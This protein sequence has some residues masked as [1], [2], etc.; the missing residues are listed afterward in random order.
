[1]IDFKGKTILVTGGAG[2]VGSHLCERLI[3]EGARVISLD[4][5]FAGSKDNHIEG[6]EYVEGHT[7]DI[8]TL[9]GDKFGKIDLVY[10]LGEYARVAESMNEPDV[11]MDLNISGTFAVLE[12]CRLNKI[13]LVYAGSSTKFADKNNFDIEG[14]DLSPYTWT[15]AI[16]TDLVVQ[17]GA[18]YGLEYAICYF[19]NVYGK[20]ERS[21][22]YGTVIQ[23]FKE[24][25][26]NNEKLEVRLPG[27]QARSYTSV[28][29]T[30]NALILIGQKG[31]GDG[32]G[33]AASE[34][35]SI[36]DVAQMYEGAEV[37][38]LPAR[39]TSRSGS[40][41]DTA[42]LASLG[43]IQEYKLKDYIN[44]IVEEKNLNK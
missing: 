36:L 1:M 19:Y 13:K 2:F 44:K 35:Y 43:W 24:K 40:V 33:I 32:Y 5:Y 6:V 27:T 4:N 41:V 8:A 21:G 3:T 28:E 30:V 31:N 7:R 18:W 12:F 42:K 26:L 34:E 10:H 9:I 39:A 14:K 20:R 25:Y 29:D 38:M 22:K 11:V 23:I 15:K 16:N 37:E 17:Y